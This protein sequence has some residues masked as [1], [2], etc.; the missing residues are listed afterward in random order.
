MLKQIPVTSAFYLNI[1]YLSVL[2][3]YNSIY[4][5]SDIILYLLRH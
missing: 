5:T 2:V 1:K 3:Q 4:L